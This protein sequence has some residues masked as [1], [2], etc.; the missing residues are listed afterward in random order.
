M[1]SDRS[2]PKAQTDLQAREDIGAMDV[3]FDW[4]L[5]L[6]C[7]EDR[8]QCQKQNLLLPEIISESSRRARRE[9]GYSFSYHSRHIDPSP[10]L[11]D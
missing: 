4:S 5:E 9:A 2:N 10:Q 3:P 11:L 6:G 8:T 1:R 7:Q